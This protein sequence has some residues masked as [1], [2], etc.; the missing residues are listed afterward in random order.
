MIIE[1]KNAV[2]EAIKSGVAISELKVQKGIHDNEN[3]VGLAK[4]KGV[5][6]VF[7]DKVVLDKMSETK[8]HQGYIAIA[9]DFKYST[10]SQMKELA[11]SKGEKLFLFILDGV[12]DP[13]NVGSIL[14]VAECYMYHNH[15]KHVPY[16]FLPTKKLLKILL[17]NLPKQRQN[18]LKV[19]HITQFR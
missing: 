4:E 18:I 8:R 13:H 9:D 2:K 7:C 19:I 14:R 12:E 15:I 17:T 10:I 1:G 3:L 16:H 5:R 11:K 6:F